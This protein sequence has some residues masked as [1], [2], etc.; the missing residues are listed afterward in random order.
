MSK[1]YG[2]NPDLATQKA[3]ELFENEVLIRHNNQQLVSSV[4]VDMQ[5]ERW[6]VA[7][8]YNLSRHP[9]LHGH[10]HTLEVRYSYSPEKGNPVRMFR[11]DPSGEI[12]L[13]TKGFGDPDT[14]VQYVVTH[15]RIVLNPPA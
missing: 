7:F 12:M 5:E 13:E 4:Y 3:I 15:E 8:A 10:E 2:M 9:G 6:A 11:S 1:F 14:F